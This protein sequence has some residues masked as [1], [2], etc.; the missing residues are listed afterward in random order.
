MSWYYIH[1]MKIFYKEND[2]LNKYDREIFNCEALLD[3]AMELKLNLR[4]NFLIDKALNY[5]E[6]EKRENFNNK[7]EEM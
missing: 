6:M 1:S 7:S 5:I 2:L 4:E 3:N